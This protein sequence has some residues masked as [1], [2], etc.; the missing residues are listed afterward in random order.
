[1]DFLRKLRR[2]SPEAND[3]VST[4]RAPR[5]RNPPLPDVGDLPPPHNAGMGDGSE[6]YPSPVSPPHQVRR[7]SESVSVA[8]SNAPR[9]S[10][11]S[12]R[13]PHTPAHF[14]ELVAP[15]PMRSAKPL[16]EA[17][18]RTGSPDPDNLL[19]RSRTIS[20]Q[21]QPR[22]SSSRHRDRD[23]ES[24]ETLRRKLRSS[25]PQTSSQSYPPS[26]RTSR[27]SRTHSQS[28][29][30]PEPVQHQP[31]PRSDRTGPRH[32][33]S[34]SPRPDSQ[35]RPPLKSILKKGMCEKTSH[36]SVLAGFTDV[37]ILSLLRPF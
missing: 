25:T 33:D 18:S 37:E 15:T 24:P 17:W 36:P 35:A 10:E 19:E 23:I 16:L 8:R 11:R 29:S 4:P 22:A 32:S 28:D 26:S 30:S 2:P 7:R 5:M 13:T 27:L 31:Y 12:M 14:P 21:S 3:R 34:T 1:M 20:M 9:H 6:R